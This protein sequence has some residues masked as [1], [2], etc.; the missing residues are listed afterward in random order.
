MIVTVESDSA[1]VT[2]MS[3]SPQ[4]TYAFRHGAAL[5]EERKSCSFSRNRVG[6][7]QYPSSLLQLVA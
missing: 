7:F 6:L 2:N 3:A 4:K 1:F 5:E